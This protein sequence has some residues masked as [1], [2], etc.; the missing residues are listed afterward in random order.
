MLQE[1]W[2]LN[3]EWIW[4]KTNAQFTQAKRAV[5][6]HE[7]IFQFVKSNE[8]Y[9]DKSWLDYLNDP[10]NRISRGTSG[11]VA[12]LISGID[13]RGTVHTSSGNNLSVLKN[14]CKV[15][16]FNLTHSAGFPIS[17]PTI[18]ILA[19]S[20]EGDLVLDTCNGT[21]TTGEAA[22]KLGR[23]YA[24]YEIKPEFILASEV[25][26]S[27]FISDSNKCEIAA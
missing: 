25:R 26:M 18:S 5:R 16:G 11:K 15:K 22:L 9:Y 27:E 19:T 10:D 3:D 24:G 4:F 6:T 8:F 14:K 23:R 20:K 13:F 7:Y 2:I 1:G 12:N 17:L 21:G